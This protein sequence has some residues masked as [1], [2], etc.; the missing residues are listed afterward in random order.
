[1]KKNLEIIIDGKSE[2]RLEVDEIG[3]EKVKVIRFEI[4]DEIKGKLRMNIL[5]EGTDY[6][7]SYSHYIKTVQHGMEHY[8]DKKVEI[9]EY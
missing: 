7:D 1:M 3:N 4:S 8:L 5:S 9:I 6:L 2:G